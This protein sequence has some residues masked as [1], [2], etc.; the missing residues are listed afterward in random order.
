LKNDE[1]NMNNNDKLKDLII[2]NSRVSQYSGEKLWDKKVKGGKIVEERGNIQINE[3]SFYEEHL[4][5]RLINMTG[6]EK[7]KLVTDLIKKSYIFL[8]IS[9]IFNE[10]QNKAYERQIKRKILEKDKSEG[11]MMSQ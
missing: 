5:E 2:N 11:L 7:R 4:P 8:D 10:Q 6:Q 9:D 3:N 1:M